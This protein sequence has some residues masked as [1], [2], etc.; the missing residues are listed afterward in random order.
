MVVWREASIGSMKVPYNF[1][2]IF[3]RNVHTYMVYLSWNVL[4]PFLH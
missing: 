4:E 3:V 2:L 1:I